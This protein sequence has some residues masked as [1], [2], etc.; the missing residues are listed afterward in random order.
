MCGLL[1]YENRM[2]K[3]IYS[4]VRFASDK[5]HT[6]MTYSNWVT[7]GMEVESCVYHGNDILFPMILLHLC[8]ACVNMHPTVFYTDS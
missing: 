2:E 1:G 5:Y 7:V 6:L 3:F 8:C 4:S